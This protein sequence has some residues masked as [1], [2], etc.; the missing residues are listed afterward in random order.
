MAPAK[1]DANDSLDLEEKKPGP[2]AIEACLVSGESFSKRSACFVINGVGSQPSCQL[3]SE[4]DPVI[5]IERE[6]AAVDLVAGHRRVDLIKRCR[7]VGQPSGTLQ[8]VDSP[9]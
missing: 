6:Q 3:P 5:S 8:C 2:N 4:V 1:L 9:L 7:L